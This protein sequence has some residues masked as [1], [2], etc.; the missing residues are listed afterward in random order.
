MPPRCCN[1]LQLHV[2]LPLLSKAEAMEYREKYEEWSTPDPIYCPIPTCSTFIPNRLIS[3]APATKKAGKQ[4]ADSVLEVPKNPTVACPKC[5]ADICLKCRQLSHPGAPCNEMPFGID[6]KTAAVLK[7]W[8]YKRCPKCRHGV[9]RMLG[10]NHMQ[11]L[12]GAQ[13]CW[14]CQ[15]PMDECGG[16]CYED[17]DEDVQEDEEDSDAASVITA[18]IGDPPI[19]AVTRPLTPHPDEQPDEQ[20]VHPISLPEPS[21]PAPSE[22][23]VPRRR[24]LDAGSP[25][26]WE[27]R[28]LFFGNEPG[29]DP[30]DRTWLCSHT[31]VTAKVD[32]EETIKGTATAAGMECS[33]CW[34]AVYPEVNL[35]KKV[36]PGGVKMVA[37][38]SRTVANRLRGIGRGRG[39]NARA[40]GVGRQSVGGV[41]IDG[42]RAHD[43]ARDHIRCDA[44]VHSHEG[45]HWHLDLGL[46]HGSGSSSADAGPTPAIVDFDG[47]LVMLEDVSLIPARSASFSEPMT[48][49]SSAPFAS[50]LST[51]ILSSSA[52]H[53][54]AP[55]SEVFAPI[56]TKSDVPLHLVPNLTSFKSSKLPQS[57]VNAKPSPFSFAYECTNC[58]MLVCET[59]KAVV[60]QP[61]P[62]S[63]KEQV[64]GGTEG[65]SPSTS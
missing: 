24:N 65:N 33:R 22:N 40:G 20:P 60:L 12:C 32:F 48:A 41:H 30:P 59:C 53:L 51:T 11:C 3:S 5:C 57:Y 21:P 34:S 49:S 25:A 16:N 45:M 4:R 37:G 64:T 63:E 28:G 26:Y 38:W 10:C 44:A 35:P 39:R 58:G 19:A 55:F 2:A 8:G 7:R 46:D 43:V 18:V 9:R 29:E 23:P 47:D 27:S 56:A 42:Q 36:S 52:P 17:D 54:N 15:M 31:F 6:E 61:S 1:M 14:V 62:S 50:S 13:W